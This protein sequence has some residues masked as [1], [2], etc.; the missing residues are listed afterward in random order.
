VLVGGRPVVRHGKLTTIDE[1]ALAAEVARIAP[2]FRRDAAALAS[3]NSDLIAP[4]LD[5]NRAAWKVP[6]GFERYVGRGS[7]E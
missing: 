3:R 1:A 6:L 2:A 5:A 4:L 7:R